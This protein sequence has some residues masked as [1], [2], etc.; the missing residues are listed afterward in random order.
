MRVMRRLIFKELSKAMTTSDMVLDTV[1]KTKL[2]QKLIFNQLAK[3]IEGNLGRPAKVAKNDVT[4]SLEKQ[5]Q[6]LVLNQL[7][8]CIQ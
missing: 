8:A 3:N 4:S 5:L 6:K 2:W 7:Y 1:N